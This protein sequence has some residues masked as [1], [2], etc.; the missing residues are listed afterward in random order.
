MGKTEVN[1]SRVV[2]AEN[3]QTVAKGLLSMVGHIYNYGILLL[4]TLDNL[5]HYRVII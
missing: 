1:L 4:E 2:T 5:A 3:L